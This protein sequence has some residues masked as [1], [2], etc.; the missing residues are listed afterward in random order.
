MKYLLASTLIA[1]SSTA[2]AYESQ[3]PPP[4]Y[5]H[6][7]E[8]PVVE[9]WYD[10]MDD[11]RKSCPVMDPDGFQ[12]IAC[13]RAPGVY[14]YGSRT[15][16]IYYAPRDVLK[17]GGVNIEYL[18]RHEMGHCNGWHHGPPNMKPKNQDRPPAVTF[19]K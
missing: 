6:P 2:A 13:T 12:T 16:Y 4:A 1:M 7:Y 11:L 9:T 5:D 18:R 3:L 17:A 14:P 19:P 8:G 15:C 10:N